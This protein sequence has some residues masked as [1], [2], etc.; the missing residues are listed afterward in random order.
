MTHSGWNWHDQAVA[1]MT[2]ALCKHIDIANAP[3][4][5]VDV[6][7]IV[8]EWNEKSATLTGYAKN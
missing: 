4:F 1:A 7:G 3:I 8:N 2:N 6:D 5:G